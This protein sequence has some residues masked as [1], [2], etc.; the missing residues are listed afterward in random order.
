MVTTAQHPTAASAQAGVLARCR[1]A[2]DAALAPERAFRDA[3]RLHA[4]RWPGFAQFRDEAARL[5]FVVD[6]D[7]EELHPGDTVSV[8]AVAHRPGDETVEVVVDA[9]AGLPTDGALDATIASPVVDGLAEPEDAALFRRGAARQEA[10][11][12]VRAAPARSR[13]APRALRR[14]QRLS[15]VPPAATGCASP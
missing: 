9:W 3:L 12:R 10:R 8:I 14:R 7:V 15:L 1:A 2:H 6:H 11:R 4:A 13:S 5:G